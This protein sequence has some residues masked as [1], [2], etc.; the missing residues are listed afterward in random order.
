MRWRLVY[1]GRRDDLAAC[2]YA[3]PSWRSFDRRIW[4]LGVKTLTLVNLRN[5]PHWVRAPGKI[6]TYRVELSEAGKV[7]DSMEGH[8]WAAVVR[9][10]KEKHGE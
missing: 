4:Q 10:M 8:D 7:T 6:A 1:G 3:A 9:A 2:G 5:P